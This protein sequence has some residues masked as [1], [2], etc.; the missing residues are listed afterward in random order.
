VELLRLARKAGY[1]RSAANRALLDR[2]EALK[3]LRS[4][5]EYKAFLAELGAAKK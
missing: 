5:G 3:P 4:R 2:T 1:F